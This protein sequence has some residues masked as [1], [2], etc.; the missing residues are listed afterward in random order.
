MRGWR[1][2][3]RCLARDLYPPARPRRRPVALGLAAVSPQS[4]I[5]SAVPA[6]SGVNR[7]FGTIARLLK[8]DLAFDAGVRAARPPGRAGT[9]LSSVNG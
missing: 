1:P 3:R 5:A 4:A 9:A 7:P 2:L 8:L 6:A